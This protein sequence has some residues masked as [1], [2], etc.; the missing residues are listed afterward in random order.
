MCPSDLCLRLASFPQQEER[1]A[2]SS[3]L[4]KES[5]DKV[6]V[7]DN[8]GVEGSSLVRGGGLGR[9]KSCRMIPEVQSWWKLSSFVSKSVLCYGQDIFRFYEV[10]KSSWQ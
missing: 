5:R 7:L 9:E 8:P 6:R 1:V 4:R 2:A 3:L 10:I